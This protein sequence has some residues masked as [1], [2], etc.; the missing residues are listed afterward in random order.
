L[1]TSILKMKTE[2]DDAEQSLSDLGPLPMDEKQQYERAKNAARD[3]QKRL[4]IQKSKLAKSKKEAGKRISTASN[5]LQS[6]LNKRGKMQGK[7]KDKAAQLVDVGKKKDLAAQA[8]SLRHQEKI[9][10]ETRRRQE[11]QDYEAQVAELDKQYQQEIKTHNAIIQQ[12]A[13][14]EELYR[15]IQS[16]NSAPGTPEG[17]HPSIPALPTTTSAM[18]SSNLGSTSLPG[19]R[20]SSLHVS[21]SGFNP[22]FQFPAPIGS[23]LSMHGRKRSSS[24]E[25]E[26]TNY[27]N[28]F[29][30]PTSNAMTAPPGLSSAFSPASSSALLANST[31]LAPHTT[32]TI[33]FPNFAN[34]VLHN[35]VPAPVGAEKESRRK[36]S[37]GSHG[38]YKGANG[39]TSHS[40][41]GSPHFGKLTSSNTLETAAPAIN[42]LHHVGKL[43]LV[44]PPSSAIWDRKGLS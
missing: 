29:Y 9:N 12:T 25:T 1:D 38:S 37:A 5:E 8:N 28:G 18:M 16:G 10:Q 13:Q 22:S 14:Y 17:G 11:L 27:Y 32:G 2:Q 23:G 41:N 26:M 44:S 21:H 39:I 30:P 35:H 42:G 31:A 36:G 24:L 34:G 43:G 20:P 15:R 40:E 33:P 19:S 6:L 7:Q 4:D 3:R